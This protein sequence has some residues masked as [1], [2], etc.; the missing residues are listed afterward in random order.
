MEQRYLSYLCHLCHTMATPLM[1]MFYAFDVYMLLRLSCLCFMLLRLS[2][3]I[4]RTMT[5]V[6]SRVTYQHNL[7]IS[8]SYVLPLLLT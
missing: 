4:Y 8:V 7:T 3:S 2:C 1:F 6:Y 5:F